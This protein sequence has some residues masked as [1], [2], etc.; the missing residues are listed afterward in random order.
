MLHIPSGFGC[1]NK[2]LPESKLGSELNSS[3]QIF[4]VNNVFVIREVK[5]RHA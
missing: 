4:A 1:T 2:H 5:K 3:V